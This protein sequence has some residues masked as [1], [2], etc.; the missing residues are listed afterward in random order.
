MKIFP[1][2]ENKK[3]GWMPKGWV[4]KRSEF[5]EVNDEMS[6]NPRSDE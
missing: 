5:F 3:S 2:Q 1:K 6:C 4:N